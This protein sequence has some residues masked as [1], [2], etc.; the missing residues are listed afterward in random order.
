MGT[1]SQAAHHCYLQLGKTADDCSWGSLQST[2]HKYDSSLEGRKI[3]LPA[4]ILH[5]LWLTLC[6]VFSNKVLPSSFAW[7]IGNQKQ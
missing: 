4:W 3:P 6:G 2:C 7:L 1:P 5:I